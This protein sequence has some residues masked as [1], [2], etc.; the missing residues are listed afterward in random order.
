[1][2]RYFLWRENYVDYLWATNITA[3]SYF[4]KS[5][6]LIYENGVLSGFATKEELDYVREYEFYKINSFKKLKELELQF[7]ILRKDI[8]R[9]IK[10][11]NKKKIATISNAE[12]YNVFIDI[13]G[14]FSSFV[15]KYRYLEPHV[16]QR[17]EDKAIA[18]I[19]K[20]YPDDNPI[21][22]LSKLLSD[23]DLDKKKLHKLYQFNS[24]DIFK[25]LQFI[26]KIRFE[27]KTMDENLVDFSEN[28]LMETAKRTHMAVSQISHMSKYELKM[29]LVAGKELD[30]YPINIR[31]KGFGLEI[32]NKQITTLSQQKYNKIII[33]ENAKLDI[34]FLC[35]VTA[36]PGKVI[37]IV[38]ITPLITKP[39]EYRKYIKTLT[40]EDIVIAPMT[41]PELTVSFKKIKGVVTDEG[42]IMSHAA[43]I[44]RETKTPC[45]ISTKYATKFFNDGDKVL[46][47][48]DNAIIQ[49]I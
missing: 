39:E 1:M 20:L 11:Y 35:G 24:K 23:E 36:Y 40:N 27:A 12:L 30:L 10:R 29:L 37:G 15:K 42:G 28:I 43:L 8:S 38:R 5:G 46:L 34:E 9:F 44:S 4:F 49:R 47:D 3:K 21:I 48:A 19:K 41:S 26:A 18:L 14:Y 33:Q 45:V 2:R 31:A 6:V 16:V 13:F 7:L 32:K 17:W 22:L 25:V